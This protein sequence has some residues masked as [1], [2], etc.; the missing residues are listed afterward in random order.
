M[1][2]SLAY[3]LATL[4]LVDEAERSLPEISEQLQYKDLRDLL[5][6]AIRVHLAAN[7]VA[8]AQR[9][10]LVVWDTAERGESLPLKRCLFDPA[11]EVFIKAGRLDLAEGLAARTRTL[12]PADCNPHQQRMEGRLAMACGDSEIA[13]RLLTSAAEFFHK[14]GYRLEESYTR[15]ALAE[16]LLRVGDRDVA[17]KQLRAVVAYADQFG[18]VVEGRLA[19]SMLA[20]LG[21]TVEAPPPPPQSAPELVD[22]FRPTGERLVSVLFIDVRGYTAMSVTESPAMMTDRISSLYRWARHEIERRHGLINQYAGDAVMATFNV[23]GTRIDHCAQALDAAQAIQDKAALM[24]LPVGAAIAVGPAIVGQLS[25]ASPLTAI[26]ETVNLAARLQGKANAGEVLLTEE[27]Y[28]RVLSRLRELKMNVEPESFTLKG[29]DAP[30]TAYRVRAKRA[31][32]S[33]PGGRP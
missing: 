15:R 27:A 25:E 20:E 7:N 24:D 12:D 5:I 13:V 8:A 30:V 18:A 32:F 29:L 4:G 3:A 1:K 17:E 28:R 11:I 10:A 21:I 31:A 33:L 19:R 22:E 23:S 2:L 6:V 14:A 16:A 26:G 9:F